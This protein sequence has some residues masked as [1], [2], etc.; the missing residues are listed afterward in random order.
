MLSSVYFRQTSH[1]FIIISTRATL[2][3]SSYSKPTEIPTTLQNQTNK[4]DVDHRKSISP[5]DILEAKR[6]ERNPTNANFSQDIKV[7]STFVLPGIQVTGNAPPL[8]SETQHTTKEEDNQ[9]QQQ[10]H[11]TIP[12]TRF[13]AFL[14]S[15]RSGLPFFPSKKNKGSSMD[16]ATTREHFIPLTRPSLIR[17]IS[18]DNQLLANDEDRLLFHQLCEGFDSAVVQRYHPIL[19]ELKNLFSPLN[20]DNETPD[21]HHVSERDRLDNEYWLLQ[22][23]NDLLQRSNFT[24]LPRSILLEKFIIQKN[25]SSSNVNVKINGYDYEVL[26]FWILGREQIPSEQ[27][28]LWKRLFRKSTSVTSSDY[29]KRIIL[30]VRLKGQDRLYLKAFRDIPLQSLPQLLPIGKLQIGQYEQRLI[31]S[32]FFIG[33]ST[34]VTHLITTMA[35]FHVPGLVVGGSSLT[36]LLALWSLRSSHR[37][38]I[39]YLSSMNRLLFYK[40]IASNK[41][42]LAMI[43]DRAEDE[44]SKDI[45]IAYMII[46]WRQKQNAN[47]TPKI[48]E[49]EIENWIRM[50]TNTNVNFK[51]DQSIEFL[52]KLGIVLPNDPS[53]PDRLQVIPLKQVVG[54]LPKISRTLSEKNEEWD[55]IEGYDKKYFEL[56]WKTV[57]NEDKLLRKGGWH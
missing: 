42:L 16:I 10:Q 38:K 45:L 26:K 51:C 2:S 53:Q 1:R 40:N 22:K 11:E 12:S 43:I 57:L 30:A 55:L 17:L 14:R 20:P 6:L 37:S 36:L 25:A 15:I 5:N 28:S 47:L 56:D 48:L 24:E 3:T 50:K 54:I 31:W 52:R 29:F 46:L 33:T 49:L 32:T 8:A 34:A 4:L 9:Q 13:S 35:D 19:T 27:L 39:N 44:L 21:H 23:I 41:Q 7:S 18:S